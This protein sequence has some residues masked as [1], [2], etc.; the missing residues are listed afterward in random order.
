VPAV[1]RPGPPVRPGRPVDVFL[2][3]LPAPL[4][5]PAVARAM[6]APRR[7]RP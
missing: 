7:A 5:P 3:A 4:I 1:R 6:R 2:P